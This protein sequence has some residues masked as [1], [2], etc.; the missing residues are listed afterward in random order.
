VIGENVEKYPEMVKGIQSRGHTIGLHTYTHKNIDT[1]TRA[2]FSIEIH[3]NQ[4]VIDK[5]VNVRPSMLRPPCGKL[6]VLSILRSF[7]KRLKIIHFTITSNDWK[8]LSV[9]NILDQV[10]FDSIKPGD[11]ISF[12]DT[13]EYTCSAIK[14]L[15]P[16]ILQTGLK[17]EK[18]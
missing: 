13:N 15:I 1:M 9:E 8:Y 12:H 5:I 2:Q 4:E 7:H 18:I 16:E 3:R 14:I 17:L 10:H 6:S 11:I